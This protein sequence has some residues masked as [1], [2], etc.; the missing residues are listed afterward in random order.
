MMNIFY[1]VVA[2]AITAVILFI[3]SRIA[4]A[5]MFARF[6][7]GGVL[8]EGIIAVVILLLLGHTEEMKTLKKTI[9]GK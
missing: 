8:A 9:I 2:T 4:I 7:I 3:Y 5:N 6:I 1:I